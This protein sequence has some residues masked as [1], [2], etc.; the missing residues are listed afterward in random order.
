MVS[1]TTAHALRALLCLSRRG[2]EGPLLAR[3]IA[4]CSKVPLGYLSKILGTLGK[5]GIV[6]ASRGLHG[7]YTLLR[8]PSEIT[9]GDILELFEGNRGLGKC[10]LGDFHPC[11]DVDACP[12]HERW[13]EV[14]KKYEEFLNSVTLA[15]LKG[16]LP[17]ADRDP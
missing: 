16:P 17:W 12:V 1:A 6:Q 4:A 7:G 5:A 11:S 13:L 2:T 10:F 9:L 3:D 15:D 14:C 8:A